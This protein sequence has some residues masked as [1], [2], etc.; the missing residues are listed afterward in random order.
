MEGSSIQIT[1]HREQTSVSTLDSQSLTSSQ[2]QK[3]KARIQDW[4]KLQFEPARQRQV[5]VNDMTLASSSR[6][7]KGSVRTSS[8]HGIHLHEARHAWHRHRSS[9]PASKGFFTTVQ[10][11]LLWGPRRL[12]AYIPI[13]PSPK[14]LDAYTER[15]P[16]ADYHSLKGVN[17]V[18][19]IALEGLDNCLGVIGDGMEVL[20]QATGEATGFSV[21]G[22]GLEIVSKGV[23]ILQ[24]GIELS[25]SIRSLSEGFG[26][27]RQASKIQDQAQKLETEIDEMIQLLEKASDEASDTSG[28][29]QAISGAKEAKKQLQEFRKAFDVEVHLGRDLQKEGWRNLALTGCSVAGSSVCAV[30]CGMGVVGGIVAVPIL[31]KAS[32]FVLIAG[33]VLSAPYTLVRG[34]QEI[35]YAGRD[36]Y[37][38]NTDQ[39][40]VAKYRA[41]AEV[42]AKDTDKF[43]H[44][45]AKMIRSH[46]T[47]G[48]HLAK[49]AIFLLATAGA[50]LAGTMALLMVLSGPALPIG[51][52][53]AALALGGLT[54]A[55]TA[56]FLLYKVGH[57]VH[58]HYRTAEAKKILDA[59]NATFER[60]LAQQKKAQLRDCCAQ[61][62][63]PVAK[64]VMN[65]KDFRQA[66]TSQLQ[67]LGCS[68]SVIA[69][70][71][72]KVEPQALNETVPLL[73][74]KAIE[75]VLLQAI[76]R[77]QTSTSNMIDWIVSQ[78]RPPTSQTQSLIE[79]DVQPVEGGVAAS[80]KRLAQIFGDDDRAL[81][82]WHSSTDH[83]ARSA[84]EAQLEIFC[85][86]QLQLEA[87]DR[88]APY[89][90]EL[91]CELLLHRLRDPNENV[92]QEAEA[93]CQSF[94]L[95][96]ATIA[97]WRDADSTDAAVAAMKAEFRLE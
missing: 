92:S 8:T 10:N 39:Q 71:L 72:K 47:P 22:Q 94:G 20:N 60:K 89:E 24:D 26:L 58:I 77:K 80:N 93:F 3:L 30:G 65:S 23:G 82:D 6:V 96:P 87:L 5:P 75:S 49:S 13:Q 97:M 84:L 56:G 34:L 29:K 62:V 45:F 67:L 7:L 32:L 44:G 51:L 74:Q 76:H 63:G 4:Q 81:S 61:L 85:T 35:Y 57:A 88:L 46:R 33:A 18:P 70:Y 17:D 40:I 69:S 11:V 27:Q 36:E 78:T 42:H 79:I 12:A 19:F 95:K 54:L 43:L 15:K 52:T 66:L 1:E 64:Q 14:N 9:A 53:I 21:P 91:Q 59:D 37:L 83:T 73:T 16:I 68:E 38:R 25:K 86:E 28:I 90:P 50:V 2:L 55:G 41:K 31:A 48:E